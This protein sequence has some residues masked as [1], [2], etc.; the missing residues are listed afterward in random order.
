MTRHDHQSR[1]SQKWR[2]QILRRGRVGVPSDHF[3]KAPD[4]M[5]LTRRQLAR[6]V[7]RELARR[8]AARTRRV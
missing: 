6:K 1:Q 3:T 7:R 4:T 5:K 8:R 2:Q